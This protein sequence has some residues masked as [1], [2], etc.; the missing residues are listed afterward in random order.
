MTKSID[1]LFK[2]YD[3]TIAVLAPRIPEELVPQLDD[4]IRKNALRPRGKR[5]TYKSLHAWL[6]QRGTV[7]G[8]RRLFDYIKAR[9][10][11]IGVTL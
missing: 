5:V 4:F 9:A 1:E 3:Q 6:T 7:I 10:K 11:Q 8:E 2:D